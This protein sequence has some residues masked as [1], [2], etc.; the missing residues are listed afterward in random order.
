MLL[1]LSLYNN[2]CIVLCCVRDGDPGA[3]SVVLTATNDV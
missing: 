2:E 1:I 3:R